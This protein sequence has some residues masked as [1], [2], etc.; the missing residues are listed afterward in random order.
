MRA[1]QRGD[2]GCRAAAADRRRRHSPRWSRPP[3]REQ[4]DL[5]VVG[6]EAPLVAGLADALA[7]A[8]VA[9]FGPTRPRARELEGSKAF[10]KEVMEA[11]GVPTAGYRVVTSVED[12]MAAIRELRPPAPTATRR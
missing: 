9:C 6:P 1:R 7:R 3:S 5:V 8:G 10:C 4:V 11:A 2:R 12:G